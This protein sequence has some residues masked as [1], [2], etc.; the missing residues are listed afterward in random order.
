M[1][2]TGS[3]GCNGG[4]TWTCV[5]Y[6]NMSDP[7]QQCPSRFRSITSPVRTRVRVVRQSTGSAACTSAF[8]PSIGVPYSRVCGRIVAYQRGTAQAFHELLF[9][10]QFSF[11]PNDEDL[12]IEDH[13]IDGVSLTHGTAGSRQHIWSFVTAEGEYD[14]FGSIALCSCSTAADWQFSTEFVGNDYF[15]DSGNHQNTA[16]SSR[17]YADD[18]LWDGAGCSHS[19]SCCQFNS[20]PWFCKPLQLTTWRS[21]SAK[22]MLKTRPF[23]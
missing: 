5:A 2:S 19:S 21:G 12:T 17:F 20:P 8:F 1:T 7:N 6:L 11:D 14:S 9:Q 13:Y 18:P 23:S 3:V 4:S 10:N 16:S 22:T 15:C